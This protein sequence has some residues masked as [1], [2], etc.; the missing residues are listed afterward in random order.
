MDV[1]MEGPLA[2]EE[3]KANADSDRGPMPD[4]HN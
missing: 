2:L 1:I 3:M 4:K